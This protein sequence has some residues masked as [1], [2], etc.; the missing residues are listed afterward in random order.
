MKININKTE[1]KA[2]IDS[3]FQKESFNS[4]ELRKIRRLA[5]KYKIKLQSYRKL[6]C[7]KCLSKLKGKLSISKNKKGVYKTIICNNCKT[8][9]TFRL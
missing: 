4:E 7:P 6:Y 9:N 8:K 1:A 5:M 3:F 2:K